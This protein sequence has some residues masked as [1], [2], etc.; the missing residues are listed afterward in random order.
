MNIMV[1]GCAGFIG[2]KVSSLL[3]EEG[4]VVAG[5]DILAHSAN[6]RLMEWR[7]SPLNQH[8]RFT[9]HHLDISD[10]DSLRTLFRGNGQSGPVK[11]VISLGALA[12]VRSSVEN[13]RAYYEVNVLNQSQ[14][15]MCIC[16]G[17]AMGLGV[18]Q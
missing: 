7:L 10:T 2:S 3:L 5:V 1:T 14:G 13:P 18:L 11:A 4:H 9:F 17:A 15:G 12:G 8:P 16:L 6:I